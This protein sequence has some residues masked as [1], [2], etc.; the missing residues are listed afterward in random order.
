MEPITFSTWFWGKK[1]TVEHLTNLHNGI[2]RH[3]AHPHRFVVV[4]DRLTDHLVGETIPIRDRD[5]LNIRDGCYVRLRMFDPEWRRQFGIK[6]LVCL[7][8]DLVI[9]DD[10]APLFSGAGPFRI[11]KGGHFN[12]C[13]FNGSVMMLDDPNGEYS[14]LWHSFDYEEAHRIAYADGSDR[15]TDQTWIA[16]KA[17]HAAFWTWRDGIYGYGK[18]GWPPG[19]GL[20][21]DARIVIFPGKKDPSKLKNLWWVKENWR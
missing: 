5:L 7:D 21:T 15:G 19:D 3:F 4:T 9:T 18:P 17:P 14:H 10:L 6:R 16:A 12:P 13:P 11:L 8:L 1:Y 20:P 2:R